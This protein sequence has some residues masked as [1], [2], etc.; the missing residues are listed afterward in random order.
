MP[1][2]PPWRTL[3]STVAAAA[4]AAVLGGPAAGS[5]A[6]RPA[7]PGEPVA[8]V[9]EAI[10]AVA[11]ATTSSAPPAT[12]SAYPCGGS[13]SAHISQAS[14]A[15]FRGATACLLNRERARHGL[16]PLRLNSRLSRAAHRHS[17]AMVARRFFAHGAFAAR[18]RHTGYMRG[19]RRWSVGENIAWGSGPQG[20]PQAIVRAWMNSPPHRRNI[21]GRFREVGIGVHPGAPVGR[22][23]DAATYTTDFGLRG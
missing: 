8:A 11:A 22:M 14:S 7:D 18:I 3:R 6:G 1:T 21:L 5:A 12:A 4:L 2:P 16:R 15:A 19:A 23:G 17:R 9:T 10:G 20:S 13:A